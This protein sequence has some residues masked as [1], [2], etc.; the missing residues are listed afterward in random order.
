YIWMFPIYGLAAFLFEPLHD[1]L[2]DWHW[3]LRGLVYVAGL[4]LVEFTTG[5]ALKRLTGKCPWDYSAKKY[6]FKGLIRWDYAPV[7]FG[8]CMVLERVHD[9]L[10][11]VRIDMV[12]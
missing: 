6:H 11:R 10:L 1:A 9:L 12:E 7:W 3:V 5:L 4:Y 2:R 8:F